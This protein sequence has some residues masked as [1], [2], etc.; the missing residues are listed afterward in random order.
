MET[1]FQGNL[2]VLDEKVI[3]LILSM[4]QGSS[5]NPYYEDEFVKISNN[6]IFVTL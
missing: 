1:V 2:D 4:S 6:V 3:D 5:T